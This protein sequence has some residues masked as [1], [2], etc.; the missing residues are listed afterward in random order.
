MR[1]WEKETASSIQGRTLR[2]EGIDGGEEGSITAKSTKQMGS[3]V[4]AATA[5]LAGERRHEKENMAEF[6]QKKREMFLVQMSLD[7]KREVR[8]S[9]PPVLSFPPDVLAAFRPSLALFLTR[10]AYLL[11]WHSAGDPQA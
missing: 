3:L 8:C 1:V 7:T 9:V 6:I 4:A 5:T 11:I 2:P 10:A